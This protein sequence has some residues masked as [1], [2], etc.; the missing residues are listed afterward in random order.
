MRRGTNTIEKYKEAVGGDGLRIRQE[1]PR[2]MRVGS[3]RLTAQEKDLLK[4]LGVF[5]SATSW[6]VRC[7]RGWRC[8]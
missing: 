2:L 6:R 3:S 7:S 4:W 1:L 8:M 5:F